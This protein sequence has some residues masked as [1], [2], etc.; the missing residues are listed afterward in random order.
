VRGIERSGGEYEYEYEYEYENE[1]EPSTSARSAPALRSPPPA[2][3]RFADDFE[4]GG[5]VAG[6]WLRQNGDAFA[7]QAAAAEGAWGARLR[8]TT[9]IERSVGTAGIRD[10]EVAFVARTTGLAGNQ[11][12]FVEWSVGSSW[13]VAAQIRAGAFSPQVVALPAA[14]A[15]NPALRIRFRTNGNNN[16]RFADIDAVEVRGIPIE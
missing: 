11:W 14:A 1:G 13:V 4:S 3:I 5:L 16:N 7:T 8:R 12:L 6:G 2:E 15:N 10:V 9:W